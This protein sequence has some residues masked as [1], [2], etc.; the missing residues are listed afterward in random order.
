[1]PTRR[2]RNKE[3]SD[4]DED[5]VITDSNP[6][7]VSNDQI[8]SLLQKMS[9][10]MSEWRTEQMD[11][12][13]EMDDR[14]ALIISDGKNGART[15]EIKTEPSATPT[16]K[17]NT[18]DSQTIST[19]T[20][21]TAIKQETADNAQ[22]ATAAILPTAVHTHAVGSGTIAIMA[23]RQTDFEHTLD[24]FSDIFRVMEHI[25]A[26]DEHQR[27]VGS[28][29]QLLSSTI[30]AEALDQIGLAGH[31]NVQH[32]PRETL[33]KKIMEHFQSWQI[34]DDLEYLLRIVARVKIKS[35]EVRGSKE[36][37]LAAHSH[38]IITYLL[39]IDK[40]V[41]MLQ[42]WI[43]CD[44]QACRPNPNKAPGYPHSTV[45]HV[46]EAQLKK[47]H[48]TWIPVLLRNIDLKEYKQWSKL[49]AALRKNLTDSLDVYRRSKLTNEAIT[50]ALATPVSNPSSTLADKVYL[51]TRKQIMGTT[52]GK[53]R[54]AAIQDI[55]EEEEEQ[56]FE[57]KLA[58]LQAPT[59]HPGHRACFQALLGTCTKGAQCYYDH[60]PQEARDLLRH[61]ESKLNKTHPTPGKPR[62]AAVQDIME[63][64]DDDADEEPAHV[65]AVAKI[66]ND[67]RDHGST[68]PDPSAVDSSKLLPGMRVWGSI[69]SKEG[70]EIAACALLD[71]G[72]DTLNF[73][74][75]QYLERHPYLAREKSSHTRDISFAGT[76]ERGRTLGTVS[77]QLSIPGHSGPPEEAII[78][79]HILPTSENVIVGLPTIRR[80]FT[81]ATVAALL[82]E[83]QSAS[84]DSRAVL[85]LAGNIDP[86]ATVAALSNAA[87]EAALQAE[88]ELFQDRGEE[89]TRVD[90]S[91]PPA[92]E[93]ETVQWEELFTYTSTTAFEARK[94]E[95]FAGY[96]ARIADQH[97]AHDQLNKVLQSENALHSF[98]A[99]SWEGIDAEPIHVHM[100]QTL[101]RTLRQRARPIPQQ[102]QGPAKAALD[103]FVRT[104]YLNPAAQ[105][106][107][108]AGLVVV[109]KDDGTARLCGD[110]RALNH[111]IAP[112]PYLMPEVHESLQKMRTFT[113]FSECDWKTAFHQLKVDELTAERLAITTPW[114]LY[115]PRFVP[116]GIACGS[117][118][119]MAAAQRIFEDFSDWLLAIHDNILVGAHDIDDM[120]N[121]LAS[122]FKR[123]A[124]KKIQLKLSKS[125]F[126]VA[127]LKFF[128]I[129]LSSG[130]IR[131][132]P[133][134]VEQIKDIPMPKSRK[135]M[136]GFLG[137]MT[138]ISPFVPNYEAS[139]AKLFDM[140]KKDFSWGKENWQ[141]DYEAEFLK[142]KVAAMSSVEL[143]MPDTSLL[144]TLFTD[145]SATGCGAILVQAMPYDRLTPEEQ[146]IAREKGLV[147]EQGT[148][149][150]PIAFVSKKWSEP[151]ARWTVTDQ[152]LFAIVFAYKKLERLLIMKPHCLC[153]DHMNLVALQAET[154]SASPKHARWRA[155]IEQ[156]PHYIRHVP[157]IRNKFADYL[158]RCYADDNHAPRVDTELQV[159]VYRDASYPGTK[160]TLV[161]TNPIQLAAITLLTQDGATTPP[162]NPSTL[163]DMLVEVHN[164]P[165]GGHRGVRDTW[166][167]LN[168]RF[169]NANIP[170]SQVK[171]FVNDCP[172]C[173]KIWRTPRDQH[174]T[175]RV[176]PVYH[177]RAVT[178]VDVLEIEQDE[179]GNRYLFVFINAFTKYVVLVPAPDHTAATFCRSLLTLMATVGITEVLW[180]DQGREFLAEASQIMARIL[181]ATF[182]FTIGNRPQANGIVERVNRSIL[183][184]L[185]ILALRPE[186]RKRWSEPHIIAI[187]QL[188]INTRVSTTTGFSPITLTFGS[189][190]ERY[191]R[192]PKDMQPSAKQE[193]HR[194]DEALTLAHDTARTSII[195]A[196]EK[197]L[198]L[199]P[200]FTTSYQPGDLV[201]RDPF[202]NTGTLGYAIKPRKLLPRFLGPYRVLRQVSN[203][204]TCSEYLDEGKKH[205]F[206]HDTLQLFCGDHE[207]ALT[208]LKLDSDEEPLVRLINHSKNT[209]KRSTMMFFAEFLDGSQTWIEWAEAEKTLAFDMYL[210]KFI[211]GRTLVRSLDEQKQRDS[212]TNP[213][214]QETVL[215]A[216]ARIPQN[217]QPALQ[218]SRWISL[219]YFHSPQWYSDDPQIWP[220]AANR[221]QGS[222]MVM[223]CRISQF[224]AKRVELTIPDLAYYRGKTRLPFKMD[225]TL[226]DCLNWTMPIPLPTERPDHFHVLTPGKEPLKSIRST[227]LAAHNLA[228]E[229]R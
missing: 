201:L 126:A 36:A 227:I 177:A 105:G 91:R 191:F 187:V 140:T 22:N 52:L 165:V 72:S 10:E 65:A 104:G 137:L 18:P 198:K 159:T 135:Q 181:G 179:L 99:R 161:Q 180:T 210:K 121:K 79:C 130:R 19:P 12:R 164:A 110:Y 17:Q 196:Q 56:E 94:E 136:Q 172:T 117:Q 174:T 28:K 217:Q 190:A 228:A 92:P 9:A 134:R 223:E 59:V 93:D 200:E 185:R 120:C 178:H 215:E 87:T 34:Q 108:G 21:Y 123:C 142:A 88:M 37:Q 218:E 158:S 188:L 208:L 5:D 182:T 147:D 203:T 168:R 97:R 173:M 85:R 150:V 167:E 186:F 212:L 184:E 107:Y 213:Q 16:K 226:A 197:R 113:L 1:M 8:L 61:L 101:P 141:H 24:N 128:G 38:S 75:E 66:D 194:F 209:A 90:L 43:R 211:F 115:R 53:P 84:S 155:W 13:K 32:M 103:D 81:R 73:I 58:A 132:D 157:G 3:V 214:P 109:P 2:T 47:Q 149:A 77:V 131:T 171:R 95:Y 144:W 127:E 7:S 183:R 224:S 64:D 33:V 156:F 14:F 192:S 51:N 154:L 54:V 220:Q 76:K 96:A 80:H 166:L 45:W 119:L 207:D 82:R 70:R 122:L 143:H 202:T 35:A 195:A 44:L 11:L 139:T 138:Y 83:C 221:Q 41:G 89:V 15:I 23:A 48:E 114:G 42:E 162:D 133:A 163:N 60:S 20:F 29:T 204:V 50:K 199:Q 175:V 74:S 106:A 25:D 116:E 229:P 27:R 86:T 98:V 153:T 111:H 49:N 206:H 102:L 78:E 125:A 129:I 67:P 63:E 57:A 55:M 152:E 189:A 222:E 151:A 100:H 124:E 170:A 216:I 46:V 169:P 118:L 30:A 146:R 31:H 39:R 160:A 4:F 40:F 62:V 176:L 26:F 69:T 145:A 71:P 225:V 6:S 205:E 68:G 193:L 112:I 219:H 148:V